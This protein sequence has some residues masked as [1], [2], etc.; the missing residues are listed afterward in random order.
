MLITLEIFLGEAFLLEFLEVMII[1]M[2]TVIEF[3]LRMICF[4][5]V[6]SSFIHSFELELLDE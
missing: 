5:I 2:S 3:V 4:Y 6:L 1:V